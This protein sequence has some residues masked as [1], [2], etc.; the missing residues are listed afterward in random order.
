MIDDVK[1]DG[2]S[3]PAAVTAGSYTFSNVTANHTIAAT[4][5]VR[6]IRDHADGGCARHDHAEHAADGELRRQPHLHDRAD[7]GYNIVDVLVD[8]VSQGA[9]TSYTF[10]HVMAN[11]TIAATFTTQTF[12]ITP[13]AGPGGTITPSTPQ[14]VNYDGSATFTIA[15][16]TGYR[17]LDVKVDGVSNPAAVTAGSFTFTNVTANHTIAA[18]FTVLTYMITPTAGAGGT[19]TPGTVQTVNYGGSATFTIAPDTGYVIDDVKVDGVS[20]PAAVTAGS[21]TFSNVTANHTIAAT[22]KVATFVITP[23]AGAGGT[24]TPGTPQIVNYGGSATFTIAPNTGFVIDDVKVDGVSNPAA[25]TA[26]SYT[27]TNVTANHTIAATF[28]VA[29]FV[30]T[31]TAGAGGTITPGTPQTVNYGGSATFA[32]A[33]NTGYRILDVKVD[34]VSNPAA[35]TAGSFTFTNV[36]A[37]HTIEATFEI[38]KYTITPTAG[39][40]GTVTPGTVQTVDYGGNAT[41]TIAPN[42]GYRI[43]DVKVDGVSNPAAVTAGSFTFTNV[44]ANHT[45]EA[46]FEILKYTIIPSAGAG[47][48]ITPGTVQTVDYGG[49]ATFTIAPNPYYRIVDVKVDGVSQG[50]IASY[51]FTNVTAD[52]VITATF[53]KIRIFLPLI[54]R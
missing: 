38:L 23:T 49:N 18:T 2:V 33:P 50:A 41:F 13:T 44:T 30:I 10:S 19:I 29:T 35:V 12:T 52:H 40:G 42:T 26:G 8:G 37:N 39:V 32:I 6:D 22:F 47:G 9:I 48:T 21:Y 15:P 4:F 28:K 43:L 51:T 45:I 3:N 53:T 11:H 7:T 36:T 17:I 16:D 25:V 24:I 14:I 54:F 20:N 1:V 31:P 46:T 27:F 34:G 5:K